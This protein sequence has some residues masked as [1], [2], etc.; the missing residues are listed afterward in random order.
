M[1]S[2]DHP[3][4]DTSQ[5]MFVYSFVSSPLAYEGVLLFGQTILQCLDLDFF[6]YY[7]LITFIFFICIVSVEQ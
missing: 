1:W 6:N 3:E 7:F 5:H 4:D 2:P